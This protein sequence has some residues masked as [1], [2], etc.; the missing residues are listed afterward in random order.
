MGLI[1]LLKLAFADD[2]IFLPLDYEYVHFKNTGIYIW[3]AERGEETTCNI[4]EVTN[5]QKLRDIVSNGLP[6]TPE[7]DAPK[8]EINGLEETNDE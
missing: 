3:D 2:K 1:E 7:G 8:F 5:I 6:N 4:Q